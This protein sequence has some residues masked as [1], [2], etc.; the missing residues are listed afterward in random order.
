MTRGT[1]KAELLQV[2]PLLFFNKYSARIECMNV[3]ALS[4]ILIALSSGAMAVLMLVIGKK[5]LHYIWGVFCLFVAIWGVGAYKIAITQDIVQADTWWRIAH[6]GVIFIP[7]L[8]VHFVSEFLDRKEKWGLIILYTSGIFFLGVN[9]FSNLLI[10]NMRWTFN[11]FYYDSPPGL[12]YAPFT[13]WVFGLIIYSHVLLWR[14]YRTSSSHIKTQIS[15]FLLAT[16]AGFTGAMIGFLPVYG[17]DVYPFGNLAAT[18]YPL[19]ITYAIIKEHLFDIRVVLTQSLV[20]VIA[21]LLFIN[22]FTSQ[23]PLEYTWKGAML[24]AFIIAGYLL[25]KSVL[26]EIKYREQLQKAYRE[27]QRLDKAKSEFISIASHQLRTPLTVI[28]GYMSM[29]LEGTYGKVGSS[30]KKPIEGVFQS[31]ERLI[32]LVNNLL[33]LSRLEAGRIK[34]SNGKLQIEDTIQSV[35]EELKIKADEKKL[36]LSLKKP[37]K[38]LPVITADSEKIRSVISNLIDN[39]IRYTEKG[40]ITVATSVKDAKILHIEIQDT[41]IGMTKDEMGGLFKSFS[42]GGAGNTFWTEG[43]G[44]GLYVAKQFVDMHKG[45]IWA[46]SPGRGK[47]STFFVELPLKKINE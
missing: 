47:G 6:I 25:I 45:K 14:A 8:F 15:Y 9:F 17:I 32:R 33:N 20:G 46:E 2:I 41:G 39:A 35:L 34:M 1:E 38:K 23:T 7:I 19:I 36:K 24:G 43:T 12:L 16:I 18:L 40:S 28:K 29:I 27:L 4:G 31:N 11:Q 3:F 42:R 26:N 22:I 37:A 44:L 21:I 10:A 13:I 5:R 30:M